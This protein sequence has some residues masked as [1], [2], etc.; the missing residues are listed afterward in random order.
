MTLVKRVKFVFRQYLRLLPAIWRSWRA[1][2]YPPPTKEELLEF[3]RSGFDGKPI[4]LTPTCT[5]FPGP[6]IK[7][8]LDERKG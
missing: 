3:T 8:R 6:I 7:R 1:P 2:A 4:D 5:G